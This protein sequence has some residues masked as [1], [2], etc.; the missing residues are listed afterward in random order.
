MIA[1]ERQGNR[2]RAI[3]RKRNDGAALRFPD[4]GRG[5]VIG[6][7]LAQERGFKV[8]RLED[9]EPQLI[10]LYLVQQEGQVVER[11]ERMQLLGK[12]VKELRDRCLLYTSDAA[13]D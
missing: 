11:D 2:Q 6:D 12:D 8:G 7:R 4:R 5:S 10:P 1:K 3:V 9:D 13:D